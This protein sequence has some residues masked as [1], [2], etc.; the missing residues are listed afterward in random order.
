[1]NLEEMV[2]KAVKVE[3]KAGLI[4]STMV[5]DSDAHCPKGHRLSHN[6]SLKIQTQ[7][8]KDFSRSEELK[9][10]D[11]KPAPSCDNMAETAKKE[12]KKEK[13]KKFR[14]QRWEHTGEQTLTTN[15]NTKIPKKKIKAKCFNCNKKGQYT[16]K[17]TKPPKN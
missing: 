9:P 8:S 7:G 2:E 3:A 1:M 15:I 13:K 6:T 10:K 4:S 17:C 16:N 11:L 5:R 14:N 12:N